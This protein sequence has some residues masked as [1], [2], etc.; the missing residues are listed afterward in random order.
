MGGVL[1]AS[2]TA[3]ADEASAIVA[4]GDR[5]ARMIDRGLDVGIYLALVA[6]IVYFSIRSDVFLTKANLL[7]IGSAIAI[8][9][10]LAAGMTIVLICGQLDLSVGAVQGFV[11]VILVVLVSNHGWSLPVAIV[12]AVGCGLV[13]GLLNG[14]LIVVFGINSIIAT[15]ASASVIRGFAYIATSGTTIPYDSPWL[16]NLANDR[17][18][19]IP[20][21]LVV[22]A[23]VYVVSYVFLNRLRVGAHVYAAGGNASAASRAGI[24]VDRLYYLVFFISAAFAAVA[25]LITVGQTA[26]ASASY[27]T[28]VELTVLT[29]VLLGGIGLSGGAGRIERTLVGVVIIGVLQNGLVLT[30]VQSYY[31]QVASGIVFLLAVVAEATRRK[32]A[33]R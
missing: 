1:Q 25:G 2:S 10:I 3:P 8:N 6:L 5:Q 22:M 26:S 27:G 31:Q 29:A 15:L 18:L 28:G 19:G 24:R 30:N 16:L 20:V 14:V 13:C 17:P 7:N 11:A 12:F 4:R 23:V 9:G 32:R 21:P 33:R